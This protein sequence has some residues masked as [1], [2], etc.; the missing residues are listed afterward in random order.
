MNLENKLHL[1]IHQQLYQN[2][3]QQQQNQHDSEASTTDKTIN[4]FNGSWP[5]AI[6]S[7]QNVHFKMSHQ[8]NF[9]FCNFINKY[10]FGYGCI[11][12][13][14]RF[15]LNTTKWKRIVVKLSIPKHISTV[16][17]LSRK[18]ARWKKIKLKIIFEL[19][20]KMPKYTKAKPISIRLPCKM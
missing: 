15:N 2:C 4:C 18:V 16:V 20:C 8:I 17:V 1:G 9:S 19:A 13:E 12:L 11:W 7:I 5:W 6:A 3:Q 10:Q 14:N